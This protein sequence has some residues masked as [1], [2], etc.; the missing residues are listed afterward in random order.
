MSCGEAISRDATAEFAPSTQPVIA[1]EVKSNVDD[2]IAKLETLRSLE[3]VEKIVNK[4]IKQIRST[5]SFSRRP[6]ESANKHP[7]S[8]PKPRPPSSQSP[9]TI[10]A[11]TTLS[12]FPATPNGNIAARF[13]MWAGASH[14]V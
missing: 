14:M 13:D 4:T 12:L 3:V 9:I 6:P 1:K 11:T 10:P 5:P 2:A 7:N 8:V